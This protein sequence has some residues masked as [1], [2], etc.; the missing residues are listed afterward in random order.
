M[1]VELK[2]HI[3]AVIRA[4]RKARNMTQEEVAERIGRTPESLSNLERG[5]AAPSIETVISLCDVLDIKIE[6]LLSV[7][8]NE[9]SRT[10]EG[11]RVSQ[12]IHQLIDRLDDTALSLAKEQIESV[13]RFQQS[14]KTR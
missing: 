10:P 6:N 13:L 2:N 9:K 8:K 3:A 7:R 12:E 4:A 5:Q 14:T 1:N 11:I